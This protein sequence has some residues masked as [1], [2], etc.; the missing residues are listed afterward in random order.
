MFSK[1]LMLGFDEDVSQALVRRRAMLE[2]WQAP[3]STD[4]SISVSLPLC[5]TTASAWHET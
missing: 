4:S 1:Q 2:G 3:R 5:P